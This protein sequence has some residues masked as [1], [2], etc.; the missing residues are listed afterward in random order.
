MFSSHQVA[1]LV[2]YRLAEKKVEVVNNGVLIINTDEDMPA[3]DVL[4]SGDVIIQIDGQPVTTSQHM[5][6]YLQAKQPGDNVTITYLR[7]EEE[8][9]AVLEMVPLLTDNADHSPH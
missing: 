3:D 4:N 7:D 2:A 6:T 5:V 1:Q 8:Y 9:E